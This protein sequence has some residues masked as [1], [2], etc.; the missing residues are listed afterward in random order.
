VFRTKPFIHQQDG[1]SQIL[2]EI[3][4]I[5]RNSLLVLFCVKDIDQCLNV[6]LLGIP[7]V[8]WLEAVTPVKVKVASFIEIGV[9]FRQARRIYQ[10]VKE[11][12]GMGHLGSVSDGKVAQLCRIVCAINH[13]YLKELFKKIWAFS[14]G[15]DARNNAGS[16]YLDVRVRCFSK[17]TFRI[18]TYWLSPCVSDTLVSIRPI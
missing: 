11:Q 7:V 9:S 5:Q 16:S 3:R 1:S 14:I 4:S 18:C 13:Q 6:T 8:H 10:T 15:L 17:V 2:H 12:T